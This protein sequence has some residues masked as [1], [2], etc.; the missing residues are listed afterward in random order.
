V[1]GLTD[2]RLLREKF[3]ESGMSVTAIAEKSGILRETLY[4]RIN[5]DADFKASEIDALTRVLDLTKEERD[6]IFFAKR[7][8]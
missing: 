6:A 1:E 4:N 2:V 7:G 8:E 5:G 3:R